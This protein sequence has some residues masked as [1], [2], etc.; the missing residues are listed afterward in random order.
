MGAGP[1]LRPGGTPSAPPGP[2]PGNSPPGSKAGVLA[3][4]RLPA[5]I[6]RGQNSGRSA[7]L[8]VQGGAALEVSGQRVK[9]GSGQ[10][11]DVLIGDGHG[12]ATDG[13]HAVGGA[14]YHSS[15]WITESASFRMTCTAVT[16]AQTAG[17][18]AAR[19]LCSVAGTA[20][21][22]CSSQ[23]FQYREYKGQGPE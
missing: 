21:H 3:A 14:S 4:G 10:S 20:E 15:S 7:A 13:V 9:G 23:K 5:G 18:R 8:A 22:H 12:L 1:Y 19:S 2:G 16:S 6:G 17:S 11:Q